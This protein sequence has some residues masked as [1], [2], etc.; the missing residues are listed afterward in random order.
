MVEG[1][2]REVKTVHQSLAERGNDMVSH[3]G[4]N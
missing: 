4:H 2:V 3:Q 1:H